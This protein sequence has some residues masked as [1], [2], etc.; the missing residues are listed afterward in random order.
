LQK[1]M[2]SVT[3]RAKSPCLL[4]YQ[5]ISSCLTESNRT[6]INYQLSSVCNEVQVDDRAKYILDILGGLC[7]NAHVWLSRYG[8]QSTRIIQV[9]H[10]TSFGLAELLLVVSDFLN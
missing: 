10:Y 7:V 8:A 2:W 6:D 5:F 9:L 3:Y 4:Y 1:M